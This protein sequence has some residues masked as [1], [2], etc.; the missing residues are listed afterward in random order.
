M[1]HPQ[2]PSG[3]KNGFLLLEVVLALGIFG[4][5]CTGLAVAFHRMADAASMAQ[6]EMRITR[7]LDSA[8]T[9]QLTFPTLEEGVSQIPVE[10]TDIELDV[11]VTPIE[12]LENQDGELLQ[13]MFHVKVTANWFEAGAWQS[14]SVETWRNNLMYQP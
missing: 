14:R 10:G 1:N 5:A 11:I 12:D 2:I 9:E 8:L 13:D 7:I 3:K 4:I 6:N